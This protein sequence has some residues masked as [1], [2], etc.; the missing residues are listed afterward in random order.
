M[1]MENSLIDLGKLSEPLSK[2]IDVVGRGIGTL[3]GPF[4]TVRQAKA[5]AKAKII[6]AKSEDEV[7][8]LKYRAKSRIEYQEAVRQHNIEQIVV[9]AANA[10]PER[11]SEEKIDKDW[12]FQFFDSAQNVCDEDMQILWG[13]I[14]A[15]E[16]ETPGTY[17][18]RALQFIKSLEKWEAELFSK[19]CSFL[20]RR[21]GGWPVVIYTEGAR[22]M[23]IEKCEGGD[24]TSHFISI[25]LLSGDFHMLNP[26][27]CVGTK[28]SYFDQ[29]YVF[30]GTPKKGHL[31]LGPQVYYLTLTGRQLA[32]IAGQE[33]Y[34]RLVE[35][36]SDDIEKEFNIKLIKAS[37]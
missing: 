22:K 18:K 4:G 6:I 8:D 26:S 35:A 24:P 32:R 12:I 7:A 15:G 14:L 31:Q 33:P 23:I 25:G 3:Y 27:D 21:E 20:F 16:I 29:E 9:H 37:S 34:D 28:I 10:L 5:D 11:V 1:P 36:V 17:T 30:T 2:L 19:Y 13:R